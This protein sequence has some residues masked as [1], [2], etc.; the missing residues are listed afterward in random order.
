MSADL[1]DTAMRKPSLEKLVPP[2]S[3][4]R[5]EAVLELLAKEAAGIEQLKQQ[6]RAACKANGL[7]DAEIDTLFPPYP[8]GTFGV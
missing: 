8:A 3:K 5:E 7:S 6:A 2:I 4:A 1:E